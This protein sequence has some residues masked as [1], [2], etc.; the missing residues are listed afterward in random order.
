MLK[1]GVQKIT[2]LKGKGKLNK[3]EDMLSS[4]SMESDV[5]DL[6]S[7]DDSEEETYFEQIVKRARNNNEEEWNR[8]RESI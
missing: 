2:L 3:N 8:K 5:D 6:D 1:C 4:P 7:T